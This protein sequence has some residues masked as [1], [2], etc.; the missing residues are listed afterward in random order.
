MPLNWDM[1]AC[2]N[3]SSLDSNTT[4]AIAI[5]ATNIGMNTITESNWREFY[6]RIAAMEVVIGPMRLDGNGAPITIKPADIFARIG[7]RMN[8][9]PKTRRAFVATLGE[10][11]ARHAEEELRSFD[12]AQR[13]LTEVQD[14]GNV[15]QET[16]AVR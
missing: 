6:G 3:W 9:A 7:M 8:I 14:A 10:I 2:K 5:V 1:T 13:E 16:E 15:Q 4:F 11:F 12:K